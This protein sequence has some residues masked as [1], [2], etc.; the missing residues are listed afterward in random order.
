MRYIA[1]GVAICGIRAACGTVVGSEGSERLGE[2]MI[3]F[4]EVELQ[5]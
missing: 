3:L 1:G 4:G 2:E 5:G